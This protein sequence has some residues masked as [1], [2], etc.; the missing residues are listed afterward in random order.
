[1]KNMGI[2]FMPI[3]FFIPLANEFYEVHPEIGNKNY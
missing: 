2:N 3:F 1:M